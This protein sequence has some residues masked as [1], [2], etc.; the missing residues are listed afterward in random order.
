MKDERSRVILH[1]EVAERAETLRAELAPARTVL[2]VHD[3]FQLE[4]A[5]A[6]IAEAYLRESRT[7][8]LILA[9]RLFNEFSQ[10][11][12][13]KL[14]EEPP[15][16]VVFILIVPSAPVLLPT[17][18]SRLMITSELAK[19]TPQGVDLQLGTL[20]MGTLF[21]YV[22]TLERMTRHEARTLVESLFY[23]ATHVEKLTLNDRQLAAFDRA[24]R[25]IG[26]NAAIRN[27]VLMVL[28][29]FLPEPKR[30]ER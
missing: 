25:L 10:N 19:R 18:R 24:Y 23:Q 22:T 16:N 30:P 5:K 12:L 15:S 8:Y 13:L 20:S 28:I 4:H 29:H 11:A 7:K 21:T 1:E 17:V 27:V 26:V 6:V 9:A 14:L 2:F 3:D